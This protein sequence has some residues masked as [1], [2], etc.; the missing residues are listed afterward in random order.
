MTPV[1]LSLTFSHHPDGQTRD[2]MRARRILLDDFFSSE[3]IL[4]RPSSS[5]SSPSL[6]MLMM[7]SESRRRSV[8]CSKNPAAKREQKGDV[9]QKMS[10]DLIFFREMFFSPCSLLLASCPLFTVC[11]SLASHMTQAAYP[12]QFLG[13]PSHLSLF[14]LFMCAFCAAPSFH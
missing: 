4:P 13:A 3:I 14:L 7:Q 11:C 10:T 1:T 5:S 6:V 9:R 2:E 12:P 8:R